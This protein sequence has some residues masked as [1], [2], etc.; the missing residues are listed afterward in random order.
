[1]LY[2]EGSSSQKFLEKT[3]LGYSR[4]SCDNVQNC[5]EK[6]QNNEAEAYV[7]TNFLISQLPL[8]YQ[9][10]EIS[11]KNLG[12]FSYTCIG[13]SKG[14]ND[15]RKAID[16]EILNLAKNGFFQ[17]AYKETLE[18]FYK[19]AIEKKY[20]LLDEFYKRMI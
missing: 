18:P 1:M 14:N 10:L 2:H 7:D 13:V 11:V 3:N 20:I 9:D 8:N 17:K 16:K 4:I 5:I 15:L 6:L 12:P 19:G